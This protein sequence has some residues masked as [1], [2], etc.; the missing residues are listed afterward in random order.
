MASDDCRRNRLIARRVTLEEYEFSKIERGICLSTMPAQLST[1]HLLTSEDAPEGSRSILESTKAQRGM[2]PNLYAEMAHS[3]GLLNTYLSGSAA[4]RS[5]SG[6]DKIGQDIVLLAISR[7]HECTYCVAVHSVLADRNKV[8]TEITDSIRAGQAIPDAKLQ[9][10]NSFTT[11]MVST[12]GRPS[13]QVLQ[14]FISAG[15]SEGQVLEIILAIAVKTISNYTNHVFNT[16]LD[17]GF[18]H[19]AWTP[20]IGD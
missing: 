18:L 17:A 13:A 20:T 4:F 10:L 1:L 14:Q 6:F 8:P 2:V 16:P 3:P 7:F 11:T 15:Y 12:R 5:G 9:A 19:R